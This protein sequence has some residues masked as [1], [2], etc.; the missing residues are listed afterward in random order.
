[1]TA[2]P[3]VDPELAQVEFGADRGGGLAAVAFGGHADL[4]RPAG[5]LDGEVVTGLGGQP[6][7]AGL[8]DDAP[9]VRPEPEVACGCSH[10]ANRTGSGG[11]RSTGGRTY[12]GQTCPDRTGSAG[13]GHPGGGAQI[14]GPAQG[15][16]PPPRARRPPPAA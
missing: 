8:D 2:G 15:T 3:L 16:H 9:G 1:A 13:A 10:G 12:P 7:P 11:N 14:P 4:R 5:D 6:G